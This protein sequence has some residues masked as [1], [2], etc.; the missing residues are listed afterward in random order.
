MILC[1]VVADVEPNHKQVDREG[2]G[3]RSKRNID[4]PFYNVAEFLVL[5]TKTFHRPIALD[6]ENLDI[7]PSIRC[8]TGEGP[9]GWGYLMIDILSVTTGRVFI[10]PIG[11][12]LHTVT[13]KLWVVGGVLTILAFQ[14]FRFC[15]LVFLLV[16]CTSM[17]VSIIGKIIT[18]LVSSIMTVSMSITNMC[19]EYF[20]LS[21]GSDKTMHSDSS[22]N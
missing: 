9:M 22:V 19:Y 13:G 6:G 21:A 12:L 7:I 5:P 8:Y 18:D 17:S 10:L 4:E 15:L 2:H 16:L 20:V 1:C 3:D 14:V 11:A